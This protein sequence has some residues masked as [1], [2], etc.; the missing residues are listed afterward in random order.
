MKT[1]PT[2][3]RRRG[4]LQ[5][6]AVIA[7]GILSLVM[8]PMG[9]AFFQET[10]LCRAYFHQAVAMEIVD[11]EMEILVAGEWKEF[12]DGRQPYPV[13]AAAATNLPPGEFVLTLDGANA[14]LE[15]IPKARGA[16]ANVVREVKV[17]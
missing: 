4:A 14:R 11:G 5:V 9:F 16:G 10:R 3:R 2:S 8:L 7:M 12:R 17:P 13:R 1:Q 6:E 15:W